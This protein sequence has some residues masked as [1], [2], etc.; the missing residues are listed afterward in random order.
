M[1][2][3]EALKCGNFY[4]IF[5][6]ENGKELF[7]YTDE[8]YFFFLKKFSE[9][10]L[11]FA[12][13]YGYCLLPNH[14][15]L[16]IK[17]KD[18][19]SVFEYLK[20][21]GNFPDETVTLESIKALSL[22]EGMANLDIFGMHISRLFSNFFNAYSKSIN[23]QQKKRGNLFAKGF[24]IKLLESSSDLMQCLINMHNS[25]LQNKLVTKIE[26]WK[27][28]SFEALSSDKATKLKRDEAMSWFENKEHFLTCH[29]QKIEYSQTI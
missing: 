18:E 12:D 17:I 4:N 7:F 20:M 25:P 3:K 1:Y 14:F 23:E 8:N 24:K 11:P 26:D 6:P 16:L 29:H 27:F 19:K 9:T 28:S 15:Q 5:S 21:N 13:L 2:Q 10:V 22:G